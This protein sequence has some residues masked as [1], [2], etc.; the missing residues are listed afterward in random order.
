MLRTIILKSEE[1]NRFVTLID[2]FDLVTSFRQKFNETLSFK[3]SS[4]T[5]L[6]AVISVTPECLDAA[7]KLACEMGLLPVVNPV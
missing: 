4:E 2:D 5:F 1:D 6:R 7:E 3:E